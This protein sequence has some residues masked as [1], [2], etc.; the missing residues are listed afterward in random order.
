MDPL[1]SFVIPAHNEEAFLAACIR[2][3]RESATALGLAHEIIVANDASTDGTGEIARQEGAQVVD[4]SLRHIAAVRNAGARAA[5]GE[6]LVF[7]D[8]DSRV[9]APLI[10]AA[11][12]KLD[13]GYVGGGAGVRFAEPVAWWVTMVLHLVMGIMRIGRWAAGSFV[14]CTRAA[15]EAVG[16]FDEAFYAAEEIATSQRLKTQGRFIVL[17]ETLVTSARKVHGR[18]FWEMN[19]IHLGLLLRGRSGLRKREHLD[20]WYRD[21]R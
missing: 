9:D 15:F 16:G 4:V 20:F 17:R 18:G 12:A 7:V 3:I 14:F 6:R 21:R 11:M 13:E 19:R 2:S 8:A 1:V 10:E 5:R